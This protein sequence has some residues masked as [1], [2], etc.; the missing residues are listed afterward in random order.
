MPLWTVSPVFLAGTALVAQVPNA[1]ASGG[2]ARGANASDLQT[3]RTLA[4]QVASGVQSTISGGQA[5]TAS[6][7]NS[8]V[9]GG[10]ANTASN[11][12]STVAGGTGNLA[13]GAGGF[14]GGGTSNTASNT[15]A[16]VAG[17]N[18]NT[19]NNTNCFIGGGFNNTASANMAVVSGGSTNTASGIRSWVP[20]GGNA[21]TRGIHGRGAWAGGNLASNGDTQ[22]GEHVLLRQ[23]TDATA[24]RLTA[25]NAAPGTTNQIVLPNFSA[26]AGILIVTAK[27]TGTTDAAHWIINC[28]AVRGANAAATTV[29]GGG[30]SIAPTLSSGTGST[31]RLDV[32]ADTTN[33]A[34]GVTAT[35]AAATTINWSTRFAGAEAVTAS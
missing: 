20:G 23:T 29:Q 33:G 16:T 30:A 22:V 18:Q 21:T 25:D 31:W 8:A 27:A 6:G 7:T 32:S 19:A 35:G 4:T 10:A 17:G 2:N 14:V 9:G 13:S 26:Y 15:V 34:L 5:N 3:A 11:N 1:A 28:G 12:N 24:T